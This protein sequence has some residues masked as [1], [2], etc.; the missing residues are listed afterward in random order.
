MRPSLR[1]DFPLVREPWDA[2]VSS[3]HRVRRERAH[4]LAHS[5]PQAPVT[6]AVAAPSR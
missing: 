4:L 3:F 6:V 5:W 2:W 1:H